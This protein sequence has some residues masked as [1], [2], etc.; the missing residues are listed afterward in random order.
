[1]ILHPDC[2]QDEGKYSWGNQHPYQNIVSA[3]EV[4]VCAGC[5]NLSKGLRMAGWQGK[6]FDASRLDNVDSWP[7]VVGHG[8]VIETNSTYGYPYQ[9]IKSTAD[10]TEILY[11]PNHDL[12]RTVGFIAILAA[13]TGWHCRF[14]LTLV[15]SS[16]F[17]H[18]NIDS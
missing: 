4:E 6:E 7:N 15:Q 3:S 12:M 1:M 8:Q 9:N 13:V 10:A 11:S 17:Q 5:G 14:C 18:P 2:N 16:A